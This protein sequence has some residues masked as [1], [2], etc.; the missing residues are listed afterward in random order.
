MSFV[1]VPKPRRSVLPYQIITVLVGSLALFLLAAGLINGGSQLLYSNRIFP[2][3]SVAEVDLSN[4]SAQDAS[5]ALNQRLVYPY[6]GHILFEAGDQAWAATPAELGMVFDVGTSVQQA[7]G[8]GRQGGLLASLSGQVH[9][10]LGGVGLAP[11]VVVDQRVAYAYLQNLAGQIDRPSVE[12]DLHLEG[13]QVV[14]TPG[15]TGRMLN[16]DKTMVALMDQLRTFRDGKITL[17]VED[18]PPVILD[19]SAADATLRQILSAPLV[20]SLPNAQ[21]G[22]PAPY[23]IDPSRL[24]E[25]M[26]VGRVQSG[27]GWQIQLSVDTQPIQQYL[28]QVSA[29]VNRTPQN[30]RFTFNDTTRQLDLIQPAAPGRLLDENATL[31]GIQDGLLQG[32]HAISLKLVEAPPQVGDDATAASLGITELV[33]ERTL[34]FRGSAAPRIQNI[35]AASA[36]FHGLLVPPNSVF[37][38]ADALGDVSLENGYAEAP[39]I[40]NGRSILGVGGGVCQVST[41][42]FQTAF[43][44]GYPIVERT[45]HAYRVRYYEENATGY[46]PNLVGLDATVFVPLVDLKFKNDRNAWLLMEVY[47]NTNPNV[48]KI[49]WKFYST[50]KRNVDVAKPVISDVVPPP[51]DWLFEENPSLTPGEIVPYQTAAEGE[52]V[53]VNRTVY[54]PDG[55][56]LFADAVQTQYEPRQA[57][58]QF[59]SGTQN[60]QAL[61]QQAGLCQP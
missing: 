20:V 43:Y 1:I 41:T 31:Q 46:D 17:A 5:L 56:M 13:T 60:P 30:A 8:I 49:T 44:G 34:Y 58:C 23:S 52:T 32:E 12:A 35:A 28:D 61:A 38:M 48:A 25:M 22:D 11:V 3:V 18:Q 33:S 6:Q 4:L 40:Y 51:A 45:P 19:A 9:A 54:Q 21:Q 39:I 55:T 53:V 50:G 16:V 42:L 7:L 36:R 15:R 37:S 24:A 2:G 47:V 27:T 14:Y 29:Q 59:G 10:R 26:R 57:I